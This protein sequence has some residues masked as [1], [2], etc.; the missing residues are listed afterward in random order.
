LSSEPEAK[1]EVAPTVVSSARELSALLT[2]KLLSEKDA[3]QLSRSLSNML[4]VPSSRMLDISRVA[5]QERPAMRWVSVTLY[6][7]LNG[8]KTSTE[9]FP[10]TVPTSLQS[11]EAEERA[12]RRSVGENTDACCCWADAA[13]PGAAGALP[14]LAPPPPRPPSARSDGTAEAL[15]R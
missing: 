10:L 8:S 9:L 13:A 2:H 5:T 6:P 7:L 3:K 4:R 12:A 14:N 11:V 15:E 1:A